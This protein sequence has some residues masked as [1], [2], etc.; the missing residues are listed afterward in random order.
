[1]TIILFLL[2]LYN[3]K[4][5]SVNYKSSEG[6]T[7]IITFVSVLII[8]VIIAVYVV[9]DESMRLPIILGCFFIG[10]FLAVLE[11]RAIIGKNRIKEMSVNKNK[12]AIEEREKRLAKA[13]ADL[14]EEDFENEL[15]E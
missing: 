15:E 5:L 11:L 9:D 13:V 2:E 8:G 10:I 4:L 7:P 12:D 6:L 3:G 1:M 14:F